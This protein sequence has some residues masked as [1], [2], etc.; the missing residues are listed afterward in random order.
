MREFFLPKYRGEQKKKDRRF[1]PERYQPAGEELPTVGPH[2]PA[3]PTQVGQNPWHHRKLEDLRPNSA[4]DTDT[5]QNKI[6]R[7]GQQTSVILVPGTH[8]PSSWESHPKP[9]PRGT[10]PLHS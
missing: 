10:T 5:S 9:P 4:L 2:L 6:G 8:S 7:S 1:T 3:L